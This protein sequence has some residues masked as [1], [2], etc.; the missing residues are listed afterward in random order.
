[1]KAENPRYELSIL[2]NTMYNQLL[3]GKEILER[4]RLFSERAC[5]KYLFRYRRFS[6][7]ALKDLQNDTA[8]FSLARRFTSDPEDCALHDHGGLDYAVDTIISSSSADDL[9]KSQVTDLS[10]DFKNADL[11]TLRDNEAVLC[12][13]DSP[14]SEHLWEKY[15][16]GS[17]ADFCVVYNIDDLRLSGKNVNPG[18]FIL[19]V[20][21]TDHFPETNQLYAWLTLCNLPFS[22]LNLRNIRF[23]IEHLNLPDLQKKQLLQFLNICEKSSP[24]QIRSIFEGLA[25][26]DFIRTVFYKLSE[27]RDESEWRVITPLQ[28]HEDNPEHPTRHWQASAVIVKNSLDTCKISAIRDAAHCPIKYLES[29]ESSYTP[30]S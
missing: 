18:Y 15:I 21:Y 13:A 29:V 24:K 25:Y 30:I 20:V 10:E 11:E 7:Y 8:S 27:Y 4:L 9:L 19:P 14:V 12:L 22:N 6:N 26:I 16:D 3:P 23:G 2:L 5:P 17:G 1:M 28:D